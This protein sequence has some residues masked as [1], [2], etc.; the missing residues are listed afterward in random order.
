MS[1]MVRINAA[2]RD[3][4]IKNLLNKKFLEQDLAI[5]KKREAFKE[6]E[7]KLRQMAYEA[8]FSKKM[9]EKMD[10]MPSGWMPE[11]TSVQIRVIDPKD[12]NNF[13]DEKASWA[14][15]EADDRGKRR[16]PY[17]FH[18][19]SAFAAILPSVTRSG[20]QGPRWSG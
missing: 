16:V 20:R 2:I 18:Q 3:E 9:I 12:E 11:A 10:A 13:T 14:N 8:V 6:E 15:D 7:K 1:T 19:T 17:K 5:E 4:T